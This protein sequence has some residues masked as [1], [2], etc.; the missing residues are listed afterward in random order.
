MKRYLALG[1]FGVGLIVSP[2][3]AGI[4]YAAVPANPK[5]GI[6]NLQDTLQNTPAG[7]RATASFESTVRTKQGQ[8]DKQRDELTKAS[9]DLAKLK[10]TL[11]AQAFDEKR[12]ALEKKFAELQELYM[13][14]ERELAQDRTRLQQD[15]MKQAE[16]KLAAIAR[17]EGVTV[18][19]DKG[20][21]VWS[22]PTVDLTAKLNAEMK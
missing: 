11:S 2:V 13:K 1:C 6:V 19:F 9:Q 3:L 15:L 5:I 14:L 12:A 4:G 8:L 16:P 17:A 22:E 20:A 10:P 21:T 18:I 7:K